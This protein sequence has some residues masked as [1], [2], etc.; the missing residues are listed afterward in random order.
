MSTSK[1]QR[2]GIWIIAVVLAIGTIGSFLWLLLQM[3][4]TRTTKLNCRICKINITNA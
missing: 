1:S 4:I 3:I 2:I